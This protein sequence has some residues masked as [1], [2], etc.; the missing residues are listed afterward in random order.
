[1]WKNGRVLIQWGCPNK[2]L[3]TGYYINKGILFLQSGVWRV[4][5]QGSFFIL[6]AGFLAHKQYLL[7]VSSNV[8][9]GKEVVLGLICWDYNPICEGSILMT[10]SFSED[11]TC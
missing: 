5:Y 4:N 7:A 3:S 2:T 8:W 10:Q 9:S 1:M 6:R 11:P